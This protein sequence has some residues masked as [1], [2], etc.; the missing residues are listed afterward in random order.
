MGNGRWAP[1][2]EAA[3]ELGSTVTAVRK[4]AKRGGLL[5]SRD[6]SGHLLV[7]LEKRLEDGHDGS[8]PSHKVPINADDQGEHGHVGQSSQHAQCGNP[9][10]NLQ[11]T[12]ENLELMPVSVHR[13]IVDQLQE[14]M[15]DQQARHD[16]EIARR[17]TEIQTTHLD[18]LNRFQAQAAL[19]RSLWLERVDAAEL[20]SERVEQRLDQVLDQLLTD[21]HQSIAT[22]SK[23]ANQPG[24]TDKEPLWRR[25]F[26]SSKRS[27]IGRQ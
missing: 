20:R 1:L 27:K 11:M 19:E 6:N 16:A 10:Q 7:W 22:V 25:L 12:H 15:S 18:H 17:I 14:N 26:G 23:P 2:K 5:L 21:R 24:E 13:V 9:V 8:Q 4:R 3:A